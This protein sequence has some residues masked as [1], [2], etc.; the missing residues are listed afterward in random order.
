MSLVERLRLDEVITSFSELGPTVPDGGYSWFVFF[1]I[2]IIQVRY[3]D[4]ERCDYNDCSENHAFIKKSDLQTL[5]VRRN[6][7]IFV[8]IVRSLDNKIG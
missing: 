1:G 6:F 5:L 8:K 7:S 3:H 4:R 2:I